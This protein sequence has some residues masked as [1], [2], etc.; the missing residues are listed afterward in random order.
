MLY[1]RTLGLTFWSCGEVCSTWMKHCTLQRAGHRVSSKYDDRMMTARQG[2]G[3]PVDGVL[4]WPDISALKYMTGNC[5]QTLT[6]LCTLLCKPETSSKN[7]SDVL[8]LYS[9]TSTSAAPRN[10]CS[11]FL[12]IS[13]SLLLLLLDIQYHHND[14]PGEDSFNIY[15]TLLHDTD[16][17]WMRCAVINK[18]NIST[19]SAFKTV[20]QNKHNLNVIWVFTFFLKSPTIPIRI[21]RHTTESPG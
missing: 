2:G 20:L 10:T 19:S 4:C 11:C 17:L 18:L 7:V 5:R 15:K 3:E 1:R 14:P 21:G 13:M 6:T 16:G 9:R 12:S 8:L